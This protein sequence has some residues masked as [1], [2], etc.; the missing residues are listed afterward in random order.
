MSPYSRSES[1]QQMD[2]FDLSY[3]VQQVLSRGRV[4]YGDIKRLQRQVLPDGVMTREEAEALLVIDRSVGRVDPAWAAYLSRTIMDF[5]VWGS[6]PTGYVD[7][8]TA[9][10]FEGAPYYKSHRGRSSHLTR[11]AA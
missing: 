6:R 2:R 7:E 1:R 8:E 9:H 3:F 10:W 11:G 5:V 4:T